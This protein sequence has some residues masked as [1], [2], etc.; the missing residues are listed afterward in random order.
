[1]GRQGRTLAQ[2]VIWDVRGEMACE[3]REA[4]LFQQLRQRHLETYS[5]SGCALPCYVG[6]ELTTINVV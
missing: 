6:C 5:N 2:R 4:L 3:S 1:M